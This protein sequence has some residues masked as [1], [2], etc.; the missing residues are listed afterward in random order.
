M[1]GWKNLNTGSVWQN[2]SAKLEAG[3]RMINLA[4]STAD[5]LLEKFARLQGDFG[6][7]CWK[8]VFNAGSGMQA[9]QEKIS[10]KEEINV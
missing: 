1:N 10:E 5:A 6:R 8:V 9:R 3:Q 7:I 4:R 2:I